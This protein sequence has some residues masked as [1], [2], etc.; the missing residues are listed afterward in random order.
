ML[1]IE[2]FIVGLATIIFWGPVFFTLLNGTLQFGA[3]AGLIVTFGIIISDLIC[4]LIC[5]LATPLVANKTSQFWLTIAGC[6]I[7]L[8]MGIKYIIKPIQNS[9]E[10]IKLNHKKQ[11]GFFSK[12]FIV[13]FTSPF[14]FVYWLGVVAYGN[15]NNLKTEYLI[16]FIGAVLLGILTIDILKVILSKHIKKLVQLKTLKIISIACGIILIIFGIRL[17]WYLYTI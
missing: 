14:T 16:I 3:R 8:G 12:G 6:L 4:V 13:N 1:F 15:A 10:H 11:A 9:Q 2:G 7:L 17:I 5:S